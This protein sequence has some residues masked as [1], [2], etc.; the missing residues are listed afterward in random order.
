VLGFLV[1]WAVT[2]AEHAV[3]MRMAGRPAD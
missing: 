1:N 2:H 3:S